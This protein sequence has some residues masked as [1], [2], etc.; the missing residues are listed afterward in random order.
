MSPG[1]LLPI[2][3]AAAVALT[4]CDEPVPEGGVD[5]TCGDL[6]RGEEAWFDAEIQP[7]FET[8]CTICHATTVTIPGEGGRR[9]ATFDVDFDGHDEA[10]DNPESTW[11]RFA[12]R[13]M[14]PMGR[15]PSTDELEAVREFLNCVVALDDAAGDDDDSGL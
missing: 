6:A 13:T 2:L 11:S 10:S 15:M 14:P 3:A 12:D 5:G 4:A 7:I 8:Y 1:F 9:G